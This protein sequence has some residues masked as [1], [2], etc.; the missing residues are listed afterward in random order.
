MSITQQKMP[1]KLLYVF[2][3]N[4]ISTAQVKANQADAKELSEVEP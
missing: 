2:I 1:F 4:E 3:I